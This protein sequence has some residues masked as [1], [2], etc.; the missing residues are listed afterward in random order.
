MT[1]LE[2]EPATFRLV[3]QYHHVPP[4]RDS[5]VLLE[6]IWGRNCTFLINVM[7]PPLSFF[8]IRACRSEPSFK[9]KRLLFLSP[10]PFTPIK[11][12]LLISAVAHRR[13]STA[14]VYSQ[15]RRN[16]QIITTLNYFYS[17]SSSFLPTLF[18]ESAT[19]SKY[20]T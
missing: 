19:L 5:T 1:P 4:S 17:K 15:G 11:K 6:I 20:W 9:D 18:L 12:E 13:R 8:N 14:A 7:F 16:V 10:S 3:A 2:F